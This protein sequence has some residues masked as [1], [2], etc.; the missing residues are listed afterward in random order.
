VR[1]GDEGCARAIRHL[2]HE[3]ANFLNLVTL[4][5]V[6]VDISRLSR[7]LK[8]G[9]V[10]YSDRALVERGVYAVLWYLD[11]VGSI[12]GNLVMC[13]PPPL[14]ALQRFGP[15]E[16]LVGL[17]CRFEACAHGVRVLDRLT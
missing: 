15:I 6:D 1:S 11:G 4:L 14:S 10:V 2:L 9:T 5:G 7:L 8:Y 3:V 17:G 12:Q 16:Y 13:V